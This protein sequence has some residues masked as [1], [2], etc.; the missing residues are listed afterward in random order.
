MNYFVRWEHLEYAEL[1]KG[2][3]EYERF[4]EK[5]YGK[6]LEDVLHSSHSQ[7]KKLLNIN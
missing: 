6:S 1:R 5:Y 4:Y 3:E 7:S 2:I